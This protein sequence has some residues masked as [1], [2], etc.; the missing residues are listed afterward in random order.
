MERRMTVTA[1]EMRTA[2]SGKR[3]VTGYAVLFNELSVPLPS[4]YGTFREK[5]APGAFRG[6]V[7]SDVRALWNHEPSFVMGRTANGTLR[8]R[9]DSRGLLFEID[10]PD[11][12]LIASFMANIERGDVNQMSFAFSV[13]RD[14]QVWDRSSTPHVRTI[15]KVSQL[16]DV[17]PV[18]YPAYP[19]TGAALREFLGDDPWQN[20]PPATRTQAELQKYMNLRLIAAYERYF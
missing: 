16:S 3:T 8:L 2:S 12:P 14:G 5:V 1:F 15:T 13:D 11:N 6:V 7:N 18:T 4:K 10:P 19:N 20:D 17:S 9:E